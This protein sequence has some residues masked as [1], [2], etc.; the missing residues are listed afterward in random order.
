VVVEPKYQGNVGAIARAMKNFGVE[1]LVLVNPPPLEDEA[2]KRAMHGLE[3]LRAAKVVATLDEAL[4]GLDFVCGTTG[5][6]TDNDKKVHRLPYAPWEFAELMKPVEGTVGLVFGREDFGL[7][8]DELGRCDHLVTIPTNP[9]YPILNLSHAAMIVLYELYQIDYAPMKA[10]K[11]TEFEKEKLYEFWAELLEEVN[12]PKH[13]REKTRVLFRRLMGR[14]TPSKWEF[15]T[16]MGVMGRALKG[17]RAASK[18][19]LVPFGN[20]DDAEDEPDGED[21]G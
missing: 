20:D 8:N 13:K 15:Y 4:E 7:F 18:A 2:E 10:L 21:S 6:P 1:R 19:G 3:V 17:T 11:A 5:V 16:M 12:W 9:D 14:A